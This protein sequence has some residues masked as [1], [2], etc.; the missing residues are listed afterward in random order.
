KRG[1]SSILSTYHKRDPFPI[2]RASPRSFHRRIPALHTPSGAP[3]HLPRFAEKGR[4]ACRA[5][6]DKDM[7]CVSSGGLDPGWREAP[8]EDAGPRDDL[9]G[10][11]LRPT[12]PACALIPGPTPDGRRE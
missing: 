1:G 6:L 8:D 5:E 10:G 2:A 4:L 11:A 9:H 7:T 3:R 12:A